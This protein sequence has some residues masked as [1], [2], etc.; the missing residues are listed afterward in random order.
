MPVVVF[1]DRV[2]TGTGGMLR[3][4]VD[5]LRPTSCQTGGR[6]LKSPPGF[7]SRHTPRAVP[8]Y[9]LSSVGSVRI[10]GSSASGAG[11]G[12]KLTP[13]GRLEVRSVQVIDAIPTRLFMLTP[14]A[15][16]KFAPRQICP[17]LVYT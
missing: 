17:L 16:T 14:K 3:M 11:R 4:P 13:T 8:A 5:G 2:E 10:R 1:N 9:K 6:A 7:V 15:K 12:E